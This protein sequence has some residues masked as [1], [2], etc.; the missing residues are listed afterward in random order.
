[1][2]ERPR[3]EHR[4]R[5]LRR[6]GDGRLFDLDERRFAGLAE[7]ADD[8]R[9][10]RP[11]QAH[12]QGTGAECTN[13]VLVEVLRSALARHAGPMAAPAPFGTAHRLLSAPAEIEPGPPRDDRPEPERPEPE[14]PE[15]ERPEPG[16]SEPGRP[17]PERP[18]P[19]RPE[20]GR[21]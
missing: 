14:R 6:E 5:R 10:G 15:P 17:E 12:R 13:Q 20:P 7:L 19:G 21:P 8:I 1:M 2:P 16:R 3:S 18:E 11:F 9:A 4:R